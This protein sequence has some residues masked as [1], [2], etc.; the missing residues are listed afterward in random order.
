MHNQEWIQIL[1]ESLQNLWFGVAEFLP[2]FL[3]AL[4]VFFIGW[5][6]GE[7]VKLLVVRVLDLIKLNHALEVTGLPKVIER[8]GYKLN[9]SLF[10]GWLVKWFIIIVF[11]IAALQIVGLDQVNSVLN[12]IVLYIPSIIA[13]A[14]VLLIA[15]VAADLVRK[16]IVGSSKAVGSMSSS[17][18]GAV[19]YWAIWIFAGLIALQ[20][21]GLAIAL[22][23]T[24]FIGFVAM[25]A[26][27]GGLAFGLG[28]RDTAKEVLEDMKNNLKN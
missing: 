14:L 5:L 2:L 3:L 9:A 23:N 8:A 1:L 6:L 4:I 25:V 7:V 22:I 10:L 26:L 15:S 16:V 18:L 24:L 28:G 12:T 11:L 13:A 17:F 27:A 21:L 20:T 19:A